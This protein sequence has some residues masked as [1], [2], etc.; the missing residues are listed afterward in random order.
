MTVKRGYDPRE[1]A[2][3]AFG[4]AGPIHASAIAKEL[5]VP[6]VIVPP[7]SGVF[8]AWGMLMADLRHDLSQTFITPLDSTDTSA[9]SKLFGELEDRIVGVF[10]KENVDEGAITITHQ[11]DLRYVGQEHTLAV[12]ASA[13]FTDETKSQIARAFDEQH[14]RVY[15]HN[16]PEEPKETPQHSK[17]TQRWCSPRGGRGAQR[18]R[19]RRRGRRHRHLERR[20]GA[21]RWRLQRL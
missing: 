15:G 19:G 3:V 7:N 20:Q 16:A 18:H 17:E 4:G 21:R 5:G 8:S 10:E 12:T 9:V 2:M 14:L 11:L 1:F 13:L 6:T